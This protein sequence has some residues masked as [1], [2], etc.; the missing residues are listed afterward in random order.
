[1]KLYAIVR[2][3]LAMTA[4]QIA[5]QAGHAWKTALYECTLKNPEL[6]DVY[7]E[8]G[9]GVN[10]LLAT[11]AE[12]RMLKAYKEACKQG[13]PGV[14]VISDAYPHFAKTEITAVGIGPCEK[15]PFL[16]K[17]QLWKGDL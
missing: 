16:A 12:W 17:F 7:M 3:D 11:T 15:L 2:M 5:V 14:V 6:A 1:M 9:Y 13:V 4:P 8:D 10:V